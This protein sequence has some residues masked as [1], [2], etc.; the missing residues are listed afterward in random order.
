M[1]GRWYPQ[2]ASLSSFN[3]SH[4][5]GSGISW[6]LIQRGTSQRRA[7]LCCQQ[8]VCQE[9]Q[10]SE[11][12]F[13]SVLPE[14]WHC[15]A[16]LPPLQFSSGTLPAGPGPPEG[17]CWPATTPCH[18]VSCHPSLGAPVPSA[19]PAQPSTPN[20]G[21]TGLGG[22]VGQGDL[23]HAVIRLLKAVC[24]QRTA[25]LQPTNRWEREELQESVA[26]GDFGLGCV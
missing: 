2:A 16:L 9:V 25:H 18:G 24:A 15:P 14:G 26:E 1:F 22:C 17:H 6:G 23:G 20:G 19:G 12:T 5:S 3:K 11:C 10:G 4:A 7:A 21:A 13:W 8:P